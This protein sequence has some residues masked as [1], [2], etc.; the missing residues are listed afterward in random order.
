M[1]WQTVQNILE[2]HKKLQS[3]YNM[4]KD[5]ADRMTELA[6]YIRT[7]PDKE[8][9]KTIFFPLLGK[10]DT[11]TC[12][13]LER[14]TMNSGTQDRILA[15]IRKIYPKIAPENTVNSTFNP[16]TD[17]H[18]KD[19]TTSMYDAVCWIIEWFK[20]GVLSGHAHERIWVL[21]EHIEAND[22]YKLYRHNHERN[23]ISVE[24]RSYGCRIRTIARVDDKD[25]LACKHRFDKALKAWDCAQTKDEKTK[26]QGKTR[27]RDTPEYKAVKTEW[28]AIRKF[29]RPDN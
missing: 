9:M 18:G 17:P 26:E 12:D 29:F 24:E 19:C 25:V 8:R 11:E 23:Q 15:E 2:Y 28:D 20:C 22:S 4:T 14:F 13:E 6:L 27:H 5:R 21:F 10:E 1:Q 3:D 16:R 7:I